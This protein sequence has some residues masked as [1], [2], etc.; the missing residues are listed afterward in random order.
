MHAKSAKEDRNGM[1]DVPEKQL[2]VWYSNISQQINKQN[3]WLKR[4]W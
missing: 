4:L 2:H 1:H 3:I